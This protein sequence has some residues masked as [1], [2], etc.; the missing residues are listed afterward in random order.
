MWSS[1]PRA[2]REIRLRD[3]VRRGAR[4]R[5][6]KRIALGGEIWRVCLLIRRWV[7]RATLSVPRCVAVAARRFRHLAFT[8]QAVLHALPALV[9]AFMVAMAAC[10]RADQQGGVVAPKAEICAAGMVPLWY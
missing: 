9:A 7:S 5:I 3:A 10:W 4:A 1:V 8:F 2:W 6:P